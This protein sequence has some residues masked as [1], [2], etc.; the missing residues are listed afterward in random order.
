MSGTANMKQSLVA[1]LEEKIAERERRCR[2]AC[3][4]EDWIDGNPT[5]GLILTVC[6]ACGTF[7]GY[8]PAERKQAAKIGTAVPQSTE[9]A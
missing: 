5:K 1:Q 7:I 4:R 8:R 3:K 2:P 6:G 9:T